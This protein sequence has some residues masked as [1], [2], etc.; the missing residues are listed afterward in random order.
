MK[1]EYKNIY[2]FSVCDEVKLRI[3]ETLPETDQVKRYNEREQVRTIVARLCEGHY[4]VTGY[5]PRVHGSE[6][7]MVKPFIIET[8]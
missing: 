5:G 1:D 7:L 6:L 4:L 2:D 8:I 3:N